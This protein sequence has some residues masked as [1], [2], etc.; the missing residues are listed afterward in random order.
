MDWEELE[1][2]VPVGWLKIKIF[3]PQ[4][5]TP[6]ITDWYSLLLGTGM[7]I[8]I[9]AQSKCNSHEVKDRVIH[10]SLCKNLVCLGT[11]RTTCKELK[12]LMEP[13]KACHLFKSR[14][15][16]FWLNTMARFKCSLGLNQNLNLFSISIPIHQSSGMQL[17]WMRRCCVFYKCYLS[18]MSLLE[19]KDISSGCPCCVFILKHVLWQ[20]PM[21]LHKGSILLFFQWHGVQCMMNSSKWFPRKIMSIYFYVGCYKC[22]FF[23]RIF[24]APIS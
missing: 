15:E 17:S 11:R 9:D 24:P 10:T 1:E 19:G 21:E 12:E 6:T 7:H 16:L 14:C 2:L 5:H 13:W 8:H 4:N 3:F 22:N 23:V 20:L 18:R